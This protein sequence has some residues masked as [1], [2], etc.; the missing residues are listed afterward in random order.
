MSRNECIVHSVPFVQLS[1]L[2]SQPELATGDLTFSSTLPLS[3]VLVASLPISPSK[4]EA[5]TSTGPI[6]PLSWRTMCGY[7]LSSCQTLRLWVL[8]MRSDRRSRHST[9]RS[10]LGLLSITIG[11][12]VLRWFPRNDLLPY[13]TEIGTSA[14]EWE[15]MRVRKPR[16]PRFLELQ[17]SHAARQSA[18]VLL[19]HGLLI[20]SRPFYAVKGCCSISGPSDRIGKSSLHHSG[21]SLHT[22]FPSI[23]TITFLSTVR[24][25]S[26]PILR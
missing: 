7:F 15:T 25:S 18:G 26:A 21:V 19:R 6:L 1:A 22:A 13:P 2:P 10:D 16:G 5:H 9:R 14:L 17:G 11:S 23:I 8:F 4:L 12:S 24:R 20:T 3:P